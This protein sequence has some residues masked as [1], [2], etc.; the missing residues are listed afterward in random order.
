MSKAWKNAEKEVAK[1]F[2]GKR[3]IRVSYSEKIG[4]VI[5]PHYSLEVKYG[6]QIPKYLVPVVP[7]LLNDKYWIC[8]SQLLIVHDDVMKVNT[9]C[10]VCKKQKTVNFLE[11]SLDQAERYNPTMRPIVCVKPKN[12]RG[13][14][15]IWRAGEEE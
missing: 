7:T 9:T 2:G 5:H 4:D 1:F 6:K 3:R 8:P 15:A 12:Y 14:I 10:W 13:F 11:D